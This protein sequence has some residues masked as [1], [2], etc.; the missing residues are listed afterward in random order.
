MEEK[1][2]LNDI[3]LNKGGSTN[4]NKKIILTIAT[5]GIVL[6]VVVLVMNTISSNGLDNLPQATP[7]HKEQLQSKPSNTQANTMSDIDDEAY[8]EEIKIE[9]DKTKENAVK[10]N[11]VKE[12]AVKGN[13]VKENNNVDETIEQITKRLKE[14]HRL[15]TTH[16]KDKKQTKTQKVKQYKKTALKTNSYYIQVGLFTQKPNHKFLKSIT[17]KGFKY[18]N[19][20]IIRN[21]KELNKIL[22]GPFHN[23]KEARKALKVIKKFIEHGA[24]ITKLWGF[25]FDLL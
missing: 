13:A 24:F 11:A 21:G 3:I 4:N 2:E 8:F 12:N 22:I 15:K 19:H 18:K 17:N 6:I 9:E 23:E 16:Q 10:E 14:E 5:L 20:K 7:Q 1:S 25:L